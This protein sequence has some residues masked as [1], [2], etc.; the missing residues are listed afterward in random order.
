[1]G[2][3]YLSTDDRGKPQSLRGEDDRGKPQ[4]LRGKIE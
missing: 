2:D 3:V 4:S 1:M